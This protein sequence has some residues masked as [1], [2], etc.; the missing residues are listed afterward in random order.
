MTSG[1]DDLQIEALRNRRG[2][3][4]AHYPKDV[5][6]AWVADMD[7]EIAA[8]IREAIIGRVNQFDCG[9]PVGARDTGLPEIFVERMRSKF[10]WEINESQVDLFNDVVQGIYFGLLALSE[11]QDGVVIQT[12]IY[13][14]FLSSVTETKRRTIECPL[15]LGDR[16]YEIDFDA[17]Q[18]SI[19]NDKRARILLLC[20]PHNPTGRCFTRAELEAISEIVLRYDLYVISD[21]IHADLILDQVPHIPIAS[22][23]QEIAARTV[24]L[25]SA[26]KAFN[27]AGV[28]M[29]FAV[30]GGTEIKNLF[31]KVPR[32]IRGGISALSVAGVTA[33]F[34]EGE[35][36][37]SSVLS[38]LR[39]NRDLIVEHA[40]QNWSGIRYS[41]TQATYLAWLDCRQLPIEASAYQF[42][43]DKAQVALSDGARFGH[44]GEGFARLNFATSEKILKE[45]LSR[46][47][48]ALKDR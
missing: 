18:A 40:A 15:N 11:E 13:P 35:S 26:S 19:A 24:T 30:Y 46:M 41:P 12:P 7:F 22:L 37:L 28:C 1:I 20:N 14:P 44:P 31:S 38:R 48:S 36:W 23:G 43:L 10:A 47:D 42:F 32:H 9:Y 16:Y 33:A 6:P 3:K 21:E 39:A 2:E 25:M 45:I 34:T 29:A 17:L 4:W 5:I 27:M 8:P